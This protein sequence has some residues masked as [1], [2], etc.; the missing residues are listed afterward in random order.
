MTRQRYSTN[1]AVNR[2]LRSILGWVIVSDQPGT[3]DK[4]ILSTSQALSDLAEAL[5]GSLP[6]E[7][8]RIPSSVSV[9]AA[10]LPDAT[11]TQSG[12]VEQATT[13]EAQAGVDDERFVTPLGVLSSIQANVGGQA[14]Y[15]EIYNNNTGTAVVALSTSWAKVTGSFQGNGISSTNVTPDYANDRIVLNHVGA[16]LVGFQTSFSGGANATV[17]AAIYLDGVRQEGLRFRRKLSAVGDVGSAGGGGLINVTGTGMAVELYAKADSGTPNFKLEA[18]QIWV[19]A[20]PT[21]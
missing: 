11:T 8:A 5:E 15:G 17:N 20:L 12:I 1:E 6:N 14:E 3:L 19:Y 2:I 9:V 16:F 18:G 21:T 13:A 10:S 4:E 7:T